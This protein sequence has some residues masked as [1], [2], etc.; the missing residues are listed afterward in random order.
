VM[1]CAT[2]QHPLSTTVKPYFAGVVD[3]VLDGGVGVAVD[4]GGD[5]VV[6]G[7]ELV[8]FFC[9][10]RRI[11]LYDSWVHQHITSTLDYKI[12]PTL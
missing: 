6:V 11:I 3:H 9:D 12:V 10:E 2:P 7:V 5:R 4:E 1:I 8:F